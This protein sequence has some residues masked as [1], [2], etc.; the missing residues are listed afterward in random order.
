[1]TDNQ[2]SNDKIKRRLRLNNS[3][4]LHARPASL[5]AQTVT[6]YS[7]NV[8]VRPGNGGEEVNAGSVLGI[9]TLAVEPGTHLEFHAE[10]EDAREVLDALE[11][12]FN[13]NFGEK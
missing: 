4:G 7:A 10:G 11:T 3:M 9:L 2:A 1:M 8:T 13:E 5:M 12:L 6:Q